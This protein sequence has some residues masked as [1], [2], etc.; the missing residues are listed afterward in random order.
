MLNF[1]INCLVPQPPL[2]LAQQAVS[3]QRGPTA[4]VLAFGRS[5]ARRVGRAVLASKSIYT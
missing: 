5:E 1:P 2:H 4:S 3:V